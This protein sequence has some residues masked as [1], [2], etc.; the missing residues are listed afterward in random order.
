MVKHEYTYKACALFNLRGSDRA[1]L[2]KY[3]D[4]VEEIKGLQE[5]NL[6]KIKTYPKLS[7]NHRIRN[8]DYTTLF[9]D[10]YSCSPNFILLKLLVKIKRLPYVS[11][12]IVLPCG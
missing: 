4:I 11:D 5:S 2:N 7:V 3:R 6:Y 12:L 9:F 10:I 8:V 1:K